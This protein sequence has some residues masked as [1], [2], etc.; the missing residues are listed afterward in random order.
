MALATNYNR[1]TAHTKKVDIL[2][3]PCATFLVIDITSPLDITRVSFL[4]TI[5]ILQ[6]CTLQIRHNTSKYQL[7]AEY[8]Q[9][10]LKI[11]ISLT[12]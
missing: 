12:F 10:L 11:I 6:K 3:S 7:L 5:V 8:Q 9:Q 1:L 2:I 4:Q